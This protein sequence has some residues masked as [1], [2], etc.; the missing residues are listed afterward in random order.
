M[1]NGTLL[2]AIDLGSNSFRLEIGRLNHGQIHRTEYLKET[3]R[4]GN[5]LDA[6]R[7]LTL[8]AMQRGWD[9]LARF[10]E[11]LAG[12]RPSQVRAV[13]TQTLREAR[14]RDV[15]LAQAKEILGFPIEVIAGREEA[16][17][18]GDLRGVSG[19]LRELD[20]EV[21]RCLV[22][23]SGVLLD[24]RAPAG[25]EALGSHGVAARGMRGARSSL[26]QSAPQRSL[27]SGTAPPAHLKH[28]VRVEGQ[29][30]R[31]VFGR[32]IHGGG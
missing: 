30:S 15:F 10:G 12:F 9:C 8:D 24:A 4:Q 27:L 28:L 29:P 17:A 13:A 16:R 22:Q 19:D 6:D 14:N 3:V 21:A 32:L 5:G 11:R 25:D 7:N 2:A 20:D 1:Q 31:Q 18:A 23:R 26:R